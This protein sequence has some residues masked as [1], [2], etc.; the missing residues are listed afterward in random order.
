MAIPATLYKLT[1]LY[2]LEH[3]DFP[4]SNSQISDFFLEKEYTDYFTVQQ[5]I[6]ELIDSELIHAESTQLNTQYTNTSAGKETLR[7]FADKLS[8]DIRADVAAYFSLNR[9]SMK[10]ENAYLADYYK[11]PSGEYEVHCQLKEKAVNRLDFTLMVKTKEQAEAIC[12]NWKEQ[13]EDVFACLM[14]ML[15]K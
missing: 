7:F 14:D 11:L 1:I 8:S 13:A 4:L 12:F 5:T 2:M 6:H 3:A 9:F 10:T 15:L